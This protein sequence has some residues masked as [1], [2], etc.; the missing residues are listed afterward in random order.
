MKKNSLWKMALSIATVVL[1]LCFTGCTAEEEE[2]QTYYV[3]MGEIAREDYETAASLYN[4]IS[5]PTYSQV[6][7]IRATL[8]SYHQY[9]FESQTGNK[10][11]ELYDFLVSTG[12]TPTEANEI[13]NNIDSR[14]NYIATYQTTYSQYRII[15]AYAEKE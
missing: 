3:E 8:R 5:S 2:E 10:R 11:N 6:K 14:G 12:S 1:A 4:N 9:D 15:W 7:E 13:L